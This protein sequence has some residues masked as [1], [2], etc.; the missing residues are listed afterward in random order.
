MAYVTTQVAGHRF[1]DVWDDIGKGLQVAG[2]VINVVNG[3]KSAPV[4]TPPATTPP[5]MF[6]P[7]GFIEK[8]QTVL[9]LAAAA[10][11]AFFVIGKRRG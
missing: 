1:G 5:G 2:Q 6:A 7:G 4:A 9:L 8:N 11:A 10:L 3:K